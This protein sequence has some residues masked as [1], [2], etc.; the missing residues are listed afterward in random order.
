M[1][2]LKGQSAVVLTSETARMVARVDCPAVTRCG[3]V[4]ESVGDL[5]AGT[6]EW[7]IAGTTGEPAPELGTIRIEVVKPQAVKLVASF[8]ASDGSR[9]ITRVPT[10]NELVAAARSFPEEDRIPVLT[11]A[12]EV[13]APAKVA[14]PGR[15]LRWRVVSSTW[16]SSVRFACINAVDLDET[17]ASKDSRRRAFWGLRDGR[18][19]LRDFD[20][21]QATKERRVCQ[22]RPDRILFAVERRLETALEITLELWDDDKVLLTRAPL[23]LATK[24]QVASLPIPLWRAARVTCI[25]QRLLRDSFPSTAY[26]G[27]ALAID[28]TAL[29]SGRCYLGLDYRW[30]MLHRRPT[31]TNSWPPAIH[32]D[33][34][35]WENQ[36]ELGGPQGI[37]V[38]VRRGKASHKW[39]LNISPDQ[40]VELPIPAPQDSASESGPYT[41]EVRLLTTSEVH[42][43]ESSLVDSSTT[44]DPETRVA[45][46]LRPHGAF[47]TTYP[48]RFSVTFPVT[49]VSLR[50]P[51][52]A[53]DVINSS[54]TTGV[55]IEGPRVSAM[56]V[57]ELWDYRESRNKLSLP[58]QLQAGLSLLKVDDKP[59]DLDVLVGLAVAFPVFDNKDIASVS[60]GVFYTKELLRE[61]SDGWLLTLSV[62][63]FKL[64]KTAGTTSP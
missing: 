24:A 16:G 33:K 17:R 15:N 9:Q 27:D 12:I 56:A 11:N 31:F 8:R 1:T 22:V 40:P 7:K 51:A 50:F 20:R 14:D 44:K 26:D 13:D 55:A 49:P 54:T 34:R 2:A 53:R 64:G 43:F 57:F 10:A 32:D 4:I 3:L 28:N 47:S 41:V 39:V 6:A 60:L 46:E 58:V 61:R 52:R 5:A 35:A 19:A 30:A 42:Y 38:S 29:T 62:D 59:T 63:I 48:V 23:R 45:I 36:T 18:P 37:E 25:N 21:L